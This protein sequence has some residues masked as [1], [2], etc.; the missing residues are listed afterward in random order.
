[1]KRSFLP[2]SF[3]RWLYPSLQ[4][5]D[6]SREARTTP[7]ARAANEKKQPH[8]AKALEAKLWGGF[9]RYA[10]KDLELLKRSP[11]SDP[12]EVYHSAWV[13]ARWYAAEK[14]YELA[15]EN[16]V[17]MRLA[18]PRKKRM[19]LRQVLL[20]ADCLTRIGEPE[21]AREILMSALHQRPNETNIC[22]AMANTYAPLYSSGDREGDAIRL[23]WINRIYAE[24]NLLPIA[25]ADPN[26]ALA[27]DNLTGPHASTISVWP[28]VTVI[29]PVY[30][31]E[32]TL[33][34][35]LRG[36]LEQTWQNL[37]VIVVDDC[38][39]DNSLAVANE[40]ARRDERVQVLRQDRN[41]GAYV[42]RNR[43]LEVATGDFVTVRDADDWSHPQ[44]IETQIRAMRPGSAGTLTH[45]TR[46]SS[47]F[48]FDFHRL[49][50]EFLHT[51]FSSLCIPRQKFETMGAW[52]EVRV[53]SDAE[54]IRRLSLFAGPIDYIM[55][56]IPMGF[57]LNSESSLTGCQDT[58]L[59]TFRH[60]VRRHYLEAADYWHKTATSGVKIGPEN[61]RPFPAPVS[62][63]PARDRIEAS[64]LFITDLNLTGELFASTTSYIEAALASG[65]SIALFHWPRYDAEVATP[66]RHE[67]RQMAQEGKLRI[68]APGEHVH[69]STVVLTYPPILRHLIDL[70]PTIEFDRLLVL[71]SEIASLNPAFGLACDLHT[72][73]ENLREVFGTEGVWVPTSKAGRKLMSED[74]RYPEP[75]PDTWTE[76]IDTTTLCSEPP[77]WRGRDRNSPIIGRYASDHCTRWPST[78]FALAGAYCADKDCDVAILGGAAHGLKILGTTPENWTVYDSNAMTAA[79]FLSDI[80][81]LV[82]YMREDQTDVLNRAVLEAMAIGIPVVLPASFQMSFGEAAVYA[83]PEQVWCTIK[84]LWKDESRYLARAQAGRNFVLRHCGFDQLS[85]RLK[86]VERC[87]DITRTSSWPSSAADSQTRGK[88][89]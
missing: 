36:V 78:P 24:A 57:A 56:N 33:P 25:K 86:Q 62:I 48:Y 70:C 3:L 84:G 81:F 32:A 26:R 53:S 65:R 89:A 46:T 16:S 75:H 45:W 5:R 74:P 72:V 40:F 87:Q 58:H 63:L 2:R 83:Q 52:D 27:L 55:Q 14:K 43:A 73:R 64:L 34:F 80:D 22:L 21:A 6:P 23:A 1:V 19:G 54:F 29:M 69:A 37:E 35:A 31:A 41:Q 50:G 9:S 88:T 12:V 77:R 51:D 17:L 39:P 47:P 18:N 82:H 66:L 59:R 42:A 28:K 10:L 8:A 4:G 79:T 61:R 15:Y 11:R 30:R 49:S 44:K 60:G 38:S 20:E 7:S 85:E 67:I 68:V 71:V 76:L 13:L